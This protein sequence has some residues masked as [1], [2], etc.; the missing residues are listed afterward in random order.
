MTTPPTLEQLH[1]AAR[2]LA[3]AG[4][5]VPC[6]TGGPEDRQLWTSEHHEDLARAAEACAPCPIRT[7]CR[8]VAVHAQEPTGAWGGTV[9]GRRGGTGRI[10]TPAVLATL[11]AHGHPATVREIAAHIVDGAPSP[12]DRQEVASVAARLVA[13]GRATKTGA[14]NCVRYTTS[15]NTTEQENAA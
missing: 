10:N 8:A 15:N 5:P 11:A 14:G 6:T 9:P 4:T 2:D 13:T 12:K 7:Q 3:H 1:T